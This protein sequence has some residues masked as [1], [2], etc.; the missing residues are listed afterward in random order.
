MKLN[1]LTEQ[2]YKSKNN[3]K[4]SIEKEYKNRETE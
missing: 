3:N 4:N 2:N 1:I